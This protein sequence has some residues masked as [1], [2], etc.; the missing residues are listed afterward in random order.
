MGKKYKLS[1]RD[2]V[3]NPQNPVLGA[4]AYEFFR[5]CNKKGRLN[6]TELQLCNHSFDYNNDGLLSK[7]EVFGETEFSNLVGLDVETLTT[8]MDFRSLGEKLQR[9]MSQVPFLK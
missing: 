5:I 4:L 2:K 3:P 8:G 1:R 9:S 7:R 6:N